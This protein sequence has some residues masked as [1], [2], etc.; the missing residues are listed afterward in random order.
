MAASDFIAKWVQ[1]AAK[2]AG[3]AKQARGDLVAQRGKLEAE[4]KRLHDRN[5][6]LQRLPVNRADAIAF[7]LDCVDVI[8]DEFV[9]QSRL[10]KF[11]ELIAYPQ[12][13]ALPGESFDS[14]HGNHSRRPLA[15]GDIDDIEKRGWYVSGAGTRHFLGPNAVSPHAELGAFF[16]YFGDEIKRKLAENLGEWFPDWRKD[17]IVK[18]RE[19][20]HAHFDGATKAELE[21]S[22]ADRRAEI[23]ANDARIEALDEEIE[24]VDEALASL[25]E[26]AG[27]A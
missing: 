19:E 24:S 20:A 6:F 15:L 7:C 21:S 26:A 18:S 23:A 22:I 13:A 16:F 8:G 10:P 1:A 9:Q 25:G 11:F 12:R 27:S 3:V 17:H 14:S 4:R 2:A 5:E